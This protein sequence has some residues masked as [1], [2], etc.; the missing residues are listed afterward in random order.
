MS[1]VWHGPRYPFHDPHDFYEPK[2]G[3]GYTLSVDFALKRELMEPP[4]GTADDDFM[5]AMMRGGGP[6]HKLAYLL[7]ATEAAGGRR[8]KDACSRRYGRRWVVMRAIRT[9]KNEQPTPR[10]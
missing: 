7:N 5:R 2:M 10:I 9:R 8:M 1:D 3:C 4:P 6:A